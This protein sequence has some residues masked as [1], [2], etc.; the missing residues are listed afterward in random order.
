VELLGMWMVAGPVVGFVGMSVGASGLAGERQNRTLRLLASL[1]I[2]RSELLYGKVLSR[3]TVVVVGVCAG[4]AVSL[5]ALV[6]RTSAPA[7]G[8]AAGF[9]VFTVAVA[10]CY[11]TIGVAVST[12]VAAS[13]VRA[14]AVTV[15]VV[16]VVWPRAFSFGVE[17]FGSG[18]ISSVLK[19]LATLTPF[20]AYSQVVS[21]QNAIL[22]FEV[23]SVLLGSGTMATVLFAW[24]VL[25]LV[26]ARRGI[27]RRDI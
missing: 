18:P 16:T 12:L 2:R 19:F 4:L 23:D 24:T 11:V 10:V 6:I 3:V 13:R 9:A 5:S 21:D 8:Q 22:A 1:P 17:I 7:V 14:V 26:V 27:E 15:F 20:G 25:S